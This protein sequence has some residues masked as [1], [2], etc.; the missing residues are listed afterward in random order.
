MELKL[1][2]RIQLALVEFRRE[3]IARQNGRM[4]LSL[5]NSSGSD[6]R[7]ASKM[8]ASSSSVS[9]SSSKG[10]GT[11][12][13]HHCPKPERGKSLPTLKAIEEEDFSG[14]EQED[15][16]EEERECEG[17]AKE[18]LSAPVV[19]SSPSLLLL[20][21]SKSLTE[22]SAAAAEERRPSF[23]P[24]EGAEDGDDSSDDEEDNED[25]D[26]DKDDCEKEKAL[27]DK[28]PGDQFAAAGALVS[29]SKHQQSAQV[30]P[31][32]S[33][34]SVVLKSTSDES[35]Q[36][37]AKYVRTELPVSTSVKKVAN[38]NNNNVSI[39][40]EKTAVAAPAPAPTPAAGDPIHR[41]T[42][43]F[44]QNRVADFCI[45]I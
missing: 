19:E 11:G 31:I 13:S 39:I 3:R 20:L 43:D 7:E 4:M 21:R 18:P 30:N 8:A 14:G 42:V 10:G 35:L 28:L 23:V 44:L 40:A 26:E 16:G 12:G 1:Q 34:L 41:V 9:T 17:T 5:D 24:M 22:S 29:P 27:V 2:E 32:A 15:E 6:S 45:T 38:G 37:G 33:S 36:G 25:E